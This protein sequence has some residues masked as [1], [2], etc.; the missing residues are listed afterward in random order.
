VNGPW[1]CL[2]SCV[3]PLSIRVPA[4]EALMDRLD[5]D[6]YGMHRGCWSEFGGITFR[7]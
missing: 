5:P 3:L 4:T 7:R 6:L 2:F 1:S